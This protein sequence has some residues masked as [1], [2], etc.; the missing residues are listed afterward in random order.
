MSAPC[1]A[2]V[3]SNLPPSLSDGSTHPSVVNLCPDMKTNKILRFLFA[4][5]AAATLL[6]QSASAQTN[7]YDDAAFYTRQT[8]FT[9]RLSFGYGFTPWVLFFTN[10]TAGKSGFTIVNGAAIG[11]GNGTT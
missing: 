7:A 2:D 10:S 5:A 4:A 9:N 11:S 3:C 8:W 1:R 6:A